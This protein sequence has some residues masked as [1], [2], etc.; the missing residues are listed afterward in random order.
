MHYQTG[1]SSSK[2]MIKMNKYKYD[3]LLVGQSSDEEE[4]SSYGEIYRD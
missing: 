1:E 3:E 4:A 2:I